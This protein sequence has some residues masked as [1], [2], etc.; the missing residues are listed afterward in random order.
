MWGDP[1]TWG[2]RG[3]DTGGDTED[4]GTPR[5][6]GPQCQ[7]QSQE[8]G[9][10]GCPPAPPVTGVSPLS[11]PPGFMA[12]EVLRDEEYDWAVDYF[13]LGV[14]LFEMVEAR[15]PFRCRGEKVG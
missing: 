9:H 3:G 2:T 8:R 5:G 14:T 12:P 4:M 1:E 6:R 15:G 13:T 7:N 11:P 10:G